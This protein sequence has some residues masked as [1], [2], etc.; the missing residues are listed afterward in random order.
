MPGKKM[1]KLR[2]KVL[3]EALLTAL[4]KNLG[5]ITPSLQTIGISQ[6]VYHRW[7]VS[8]VEFKTKVECIRNIALDFVESKLYQLIKEGD[9]T[10]IIFYLKCKGKERGYIDRQVIEFGGKGKIEFN[11]GEEDEI[12]EE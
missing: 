2:E 1:S 12:K 5:V 8:D 4:E 3:K 11:F 6:P 9:K 10:S 7:M